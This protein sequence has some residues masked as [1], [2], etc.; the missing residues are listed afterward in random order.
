MVPSKN[1]PRRF[2][3]GG[4]LR[5]LL[6]HDNLYFM[7]R[8]IAAE[9]RRGVRSAL[10]I[11]SMAEFDTNVARRLTPMWHV[12]IKG[13]KRLRRCLSRVSVQLPCSRQ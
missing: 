7:D 5:P 6:A 13:C 10:K 11:D 3:K 4:F 2:P 9:Q 1:W 12:W 8:R